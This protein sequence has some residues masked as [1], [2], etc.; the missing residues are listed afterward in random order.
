MIQKKTNYFF[1]FLLLVTFAIQSQADNLQLN[2]HEK[3]YL[4]E[5]PV[6]N[7]CVDPDWLPYEKLDAQ[8]KH[9]GL[10]AEYMDLFQHKLNITFKVLKSKSWID[11][12]EHY[13]KGQCD[14]VSALNKTE[15]RSNYLLFTPAYIKSPA[16][17]VLHESNQHDTQLTDLKDKTLAMVKGYVYDEKLRHKYPEIK[18]IYQENMEEALKKVST[19][20]IDATLGPLFLAFALTQQPELNNLKIIGKAEF[21][22]ELRVGINKDKQLLAAIFTK[23]VLSLSPEEHTE[24]RGAWAKKRQQ[25]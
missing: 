18:I 14:I 4:L 23:L 16:V 10:V 19:K 5:H 3:N 8:G 15:K 9:I 25:H 22:D 24:V 1:L 11:T 21:E 7:V 20:K 2:S 6:L 13:E 12:Q 17:L